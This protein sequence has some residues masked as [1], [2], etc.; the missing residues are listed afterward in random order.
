MVMRRCDALMPHSSVRGPMAPGNAC[1]N[2]KCRPAENLHVCT[3]H[4]CST[5]SQLCI[6]AFKGVPAKSE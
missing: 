1:V 4:A 6:L 5:H 2:C 3:A